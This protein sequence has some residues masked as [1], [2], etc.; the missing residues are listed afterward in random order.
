MADFLLIRPANDAAALDLSNWCTNLIPTLAAGGHTVAG[1]LHATAATRAAIRSN[2]PA[3]RCVTFWGHGTS[4]QLRG[5]GGPL[6]DTANVGLAAGSIFLAIACSSADVLGPDAISQGV[7]AWLGFNN[8]FVWVS[9]DPD[10]QFEPAIAAGVK[11]LIA[12]GDV[13]SARAAIFT[14]LQRAFVFYQT[15]AGR[16]TTNSTFGWLAASH[17]SSRLT[18]VGNPAATL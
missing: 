2:L 9:R 6:V 4:T 11:D 14:G 18:L 17:D 13:D 12:G 5:A 16:G 1:D 7:E 15:G 3:K 10:R 8:L